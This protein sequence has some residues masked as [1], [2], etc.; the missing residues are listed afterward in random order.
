MAASL[1][2]IKRAQDEDKP[3][4]VWFNPSKKFPI[5]YNV[6]LDPFESFDNLTDRSDI[7]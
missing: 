5:F 2:F 7:V 4:F 3:Y 1:V 6:H